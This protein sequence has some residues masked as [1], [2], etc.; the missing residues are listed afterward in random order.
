MPSEDLLPEPLPDDPLPLFAVWLQDAVAKRVQPN[1][2]AMVLATTDPDC[3]PSARV[4]L[5]KRIDVRSGYVVFFTNYDSR[6]S[7]ELLQHPRASAVLHWDALH[8]QVRLEGAVVRSPAAESDEYFA[9]R[10]LD[11]RIGAWASRQSEPLASRAALADQ[12]KAMRTK[13][14]VAEG[15]TTGNVPR[16]PNWGGYRLWIDTIE[17]WVE[18]PYRVHDR[19]VWNR[20]LRPAG[21]D[22]FAA[23]AWRSTRLNP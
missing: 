12:V 4:V 6:K 21:N 11:S 16:P 1:P 5:C 18:G 10:S 7:R 20:E 19:A 15:A 14:R 2:D 17:L 8:R 13:F 3:R 9:S 22:S 23:A